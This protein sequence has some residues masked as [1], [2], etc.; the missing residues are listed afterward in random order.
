VTSA[1]EELLGAPLVITAKDQRDAQDEIGEAIVASARRDID[2]FIAVLARER[3]LLESSEVV[4]ALGRVDDR[5]VIP[6]LLDAL[7]SREP[8]VRWG[9]A[10]ALEHRREARVVDAFIAALADRSETVRLVVAEALGDFAEPRAL[11]PLC[12]AAA[13]RSNQPQRIRRVFDAAIAK[14]RR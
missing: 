11:G 12:A 7:R 8:L 2:R 9:A 4:W 14:L 13:K 1:F 6:F 3:S 10:R 5:R